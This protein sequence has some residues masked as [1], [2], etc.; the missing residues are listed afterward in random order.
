M[1]SPY[2]HEL[3]PKKKTRTISISSRLR[4]ASELFDD[5]IIEPRQK[6]V[7]KDL[8]ISGDPRLMDALHQYEL[9]NKEPMQN[10]VKEVC[11]EMEKEAISN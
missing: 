4:S 1:T 10:M 11:K 9:G 5:G 8:I 2:N 6:G 3:P 7:I